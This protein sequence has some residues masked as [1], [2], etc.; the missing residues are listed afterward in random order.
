MILNSNSGKAAQP[1]PLAGAIREAGVLPGK[2]QAGP[3]GVQP[4]QLASKLT[5]VSC[6]SGIDLIKYA[7]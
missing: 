5:L 4:A 7:C 1:S 3:F 2:L 6:F